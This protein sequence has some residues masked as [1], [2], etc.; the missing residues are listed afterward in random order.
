MQ[1][2]I[3]LQKS[4]LFYPMEQGDISENSNNYH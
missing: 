4:G 1:P 3:E 2:L